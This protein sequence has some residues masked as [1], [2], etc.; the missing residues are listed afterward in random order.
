M[1]I[2]RNENCPCGSGKKYKHCCLKLAADIRITWK[3][4][5]SLISSDEKLDTRIGKV[6][7][8]LLDFLC[9][10]NWAGACHGTSAI[11]YVIYRELGFDPMLCTGVVE[12]GIWVTGHSWI[13]L[14]G[15]IFDAACY[16]PNEGCPKAMPV[17]NGLELQTLI[18]PEASYGV[19]VPFES[20]ED[21]QIMVDNNTTLSKI[22]GSELESIEGA[23]LWSAL[24]SICVLADIATPLRVIGDSIDPTDLAEKYKDVRWTLCDKIPVNGI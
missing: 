8:A 24:D 16:F 22:L 5:I 21:V 2:G 9:Q 4:D 1:K 15:E 11:L 20:V 10:T 23:R 12:R 6:F 7:F 19:A 3:A 17:F 14:G 18:S 13:E